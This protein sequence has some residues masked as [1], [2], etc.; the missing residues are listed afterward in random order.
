ML[1]RPD[2][3]RMMTGMSS[4]PSVQTAPLPPA[5]DSIA[6]ALA[7]LIG[8]GAAAAC[9]LLSPRGLFHFDDLTHYLY[10]KWA[11]R[12]PAYLLNEWGRPGFTAAYFLPAAWGWV[13]C[14]FLSVA[15][16]GA[17]AWLAYLI[18]R[19][20]GLARAWLA[21]PLML[22][23]PLAF[24]LAQTTLTETPLALYLALAHY[25]ALRGRWSWS[26]AV[27]SIA[28]L[29]R[30]E[31]AVFVPVWAAAALAGKVPLWRLWPIIWAP[32]VAN[33]AAWL[34]GTP[35][36]MEVLF[37]PRPTDE[38]GAGGWFSFVAR[39]LR[40]WGPGVTILAVT[41]VAPLVQRRGGGLVACS[42]I[43]WF[44]AQTIIRALGLFA[45]GGYDRFLVPVAPLMAIAAVAGWNRLCTADARDRLR[46][47][48]V[49]A[50]SML[51]IWLS[52]ERE[53]V[54]S[55][56]PGAA[57]FEFPRKDVAVLAIRIVTGAVLLAAGLAGLFSRMPSRR[58]DRLPQLLV[59]TA[60]ALIIALTFVA[61]CGPLSMP[62]QAPLITQALTGATDLG[63]DRRPV[64]AAVPWIDHVLDAW[65]P[66]DRPYFHIR[67]EQ[68]P[69]GAL[70][71][72]ERQFA[73]SSSRGKLRPSLESSPCFRE[74]IRSDPLPYEREPYLVVF[75]K[76]CD[77]PTRAEMEL[78]Q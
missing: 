41:G 36:P 55:D 38:Y 9:V 49:A 51:S 68:A 26:S 75:E 31:S 24:Q 8:M 53:I 78:E 54:I 77:T 17:A 45:S 47:I 3:P 33:G 10:A 22:A 72:W 1:Y 57:P 59:P 19:H 18:A 63:L 39:T 4:E 2:R 73:E 14:K 11:W 40:A 37:S 71:A 70:I 32:V 52:L 34:T 44:L 61:L 20:L 23:Q 27:L 15:L 43:I 5:R 7:L 25:L 74:V 60:I 69:V 67:V 28:L 16:T 12:W 30:H 65:Q 76:I 35:L 50:I 42:I 62:P 56:L 64:I 21:V 58:S 13:A 29:T 48:F 6:A 66:P 46:A